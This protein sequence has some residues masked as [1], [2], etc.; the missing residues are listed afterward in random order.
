MADASSVGAVEVGVDGFRPDVR[1]L[2]AARLAMQVV[3]AVG[4]GEMHLLARVRA[5]RLHRLPPLFGRTSETFSLAKVDY[6][7]PILVSSQMEVDKNM[8]G[9]KACRAKLKVLQLQLGD[10]I[11]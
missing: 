6:T 7:N 1:E 11:W 5:D 2:A 8:P 10:E 9:R 3:M 4:A